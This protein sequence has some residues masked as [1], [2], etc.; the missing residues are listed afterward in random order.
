[1]IRVR[2]AT[3][4]ASATIFA[5]L[6]DVLAD[7]KTGP[8][9]YITALAVNFFTLAFAFITALEVVMRQPGE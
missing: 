8:A 6:V 3:R 9:A 1:V 5:M 7:P 4:L 2:V